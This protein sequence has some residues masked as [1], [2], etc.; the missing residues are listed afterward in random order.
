[1]NK[2]VHKIVKNGGIIKGAIPIYK[3]NNEYINAYPFIENECQW[4]EI[5]DKNVSFDTENIRYSIDTKKINGKYGRAVIVLDEK[6]GK[7]AIV[8]V[9]IIPDFNAAIDKYSFLYTD[10]GKITVRNNTGNNAVIKAVSSE[11]FIKFK[12]MKQNGKDTV[13]PFEIKVPIFLKTQVELS[14]K[15]YI[16]ASVTVNFIQNNKTQSRT[17]NITAGTG[18]AE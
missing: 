4:L 17:F 10:E 1:M 18:F 9:F 11:G 13:I 5:I 8:E 15:P 16:T 6:R 14:G 2:T 3:E 12:N 7:K